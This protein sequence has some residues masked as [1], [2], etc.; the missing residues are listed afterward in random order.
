MKEAAKM[1]MYALSLLVSWLKFRRFGSNLHLYSHK[2]VALIGYLF[3]VQAFLFG[4]YHQGLFYIAIGLF[5]F[6]SVE[7]ILIQLIS[8][9]INEH[10]VL[11]LTNLPREGEGK[12]YITGY[13]FSDKRFLWPW[14]SG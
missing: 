5:I 7:A 3:M 13:G 14:R 9:G 10:I 4:G 1:L 11:K 6:S 12:V 8:K 2:A